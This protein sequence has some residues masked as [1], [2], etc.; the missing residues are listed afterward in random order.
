[1]VAGLWGC[2]ADPPSIDG[3]SQGDSTS[4]GPATSGSSGDTTT[5]TGT[6]G[7][8]SGTS[9]AETSTSGTATTETSE[10]AATSESSDLTS[11][12]SSS[13]ATAEETASDGPL[14]IELAAPQGILVDGRTPIRVTFNRDV[15]ATTADVTVRLDTAIDVGGSVEVTDATLEFVPATPFAQVGHYEVT[16]GVGVTDLAGEALP[17][18]FT[19]AFEVPRSGNGDAPPFELAPQG[20]TDVVCP[21]L[22]MDNAGNVMALFERDGTLYTSYYEAGMGWHA[23]AELAEGRDATLGMSPGGRAAVLYTATVSEAPRV[24]LRTTEPYS[25]AFGTAELADANMAE[26]VRTGGPCDLTH[27]NRAVAINDAGAVAAAWRTYDTPIVGGDPVLG[28]VARVREADGTW[29]MRWFESTYHLLNETE[30]LA[31]AIDLYGNAQISFGNGQIGENEYVLLRSNVP[32]QD[33]SSDV[34][35]YYGQATAPR[36]QIGLDGEFV[37]GLAAYEWPPSVPENQ[38]RIEV[39]GTTSEDTPVSVDLLAPILADATDVSLSTRGGRWIAWREGMNIGA[40]GLLDTTWEWNPSV[41]SDDGGTFPIIVGRGDESA[42]VAWSSA[43]A[44]AFGHLAYSPSLLVLTIEEVATLP[45]DG[46]A[47][48][49]RMVFDPPSGHGIITWVGDDGGLSAH[50]FHNLPPAG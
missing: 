41:V 33:W 6:S 27:Q 43:S 8:P 1:M 29:G 25:A 23:T 38:I 20:A 11:E 32:A 45:T 17:A 26:T 14:S 31:A 13:A 21:H 40:A 49:P 16:V 35:G 15:M 5:G 3:G 46:M 48:S 19:F 37:R 18:P 34:V 47:T 2:P 4:L 22:A 7:G 50:A 24:L 42:I 30:A 36:L 39:R 12:A 10:S 9:Q 44:V 28:V